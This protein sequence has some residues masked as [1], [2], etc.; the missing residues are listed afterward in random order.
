MSMRASGAEGGG[1][2]IAVRN[3]VQS[4]WTERRTE[5][6]EGGEGERESASEEQS[7]KDKV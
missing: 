7:R 4:E 2:E 1:R 5:E 3:S 6:F